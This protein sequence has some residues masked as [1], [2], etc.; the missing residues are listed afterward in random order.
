MHS[1]N[2]TTRRELSDETVRLQAEALRAYV[3]RGGSASRW[4]DSRD[5]LPGDRA[6]V[7]LAWADLEEHVA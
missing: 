2:P 4:L 1:V 7:L 5:I 3:A 6:A